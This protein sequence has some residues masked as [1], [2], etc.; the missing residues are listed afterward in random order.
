M[1]DPK[2]ECLTVPSRHALDMMTLRGLSLADFDRM[3]RAARWTP[4]GG[5]KVDAVCRRWHLKLN[6]VP[7]HIELITAFQL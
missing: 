5:R 1:G 6:V 3:V 7:C 2:K 4:E